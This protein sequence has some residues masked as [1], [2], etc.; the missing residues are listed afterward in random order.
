LIGERVALLIGLFVVPALLLA[1]GNR[2]RRRTPLWRRVFWGGVTGHTLGLVVTVA[3]T[4]WPPVWW[5]Q[6]P[7]W[8]DAAVHWT[9]GFGA[10]LGAALAAALPAVQALRRGE[11]PSG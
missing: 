8:R 7:F 2:L 1:L 5:H 10:L 6:G 9:L 11:D 3:A 4:L